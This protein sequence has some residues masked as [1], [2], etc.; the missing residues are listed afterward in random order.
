MTGSPHGAKR[1][2]EAFSEQLN[3]RE[4]NDLDTSPRSDLKRRA[5]GRTV[6]FLRRL[7]FHVAKVRQVLRWK[8]EIETGASPVFVAGICGRKY[9]ALI[10][11]SGLIEW[12]SGVL[13]NTT[14]SLTP[15]VF[16]KFNQVICQHL[17]AA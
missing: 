7:R 5:V 9:R 2:G 6:R 15:P 14:R 11:I 16:N 3:Q 13:T 10:Q 12:L 17:R 8:T 1:R 4:V